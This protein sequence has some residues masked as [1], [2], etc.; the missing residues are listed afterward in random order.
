MV[1][2]PPVPR[3]ATVPTITPYLAQ[4]HLDS[5]TRRVMDLAFEITC[6]AVTHTDL[7]ETRQSLIAT[8]IIELADA[9]EADPERIC[10][11]TLSHLRTM[12]LL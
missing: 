7:D 9:G 12:G 6:A 8:K 1:A 3:Q 2:L 10:E 5:E 4:A 11:R